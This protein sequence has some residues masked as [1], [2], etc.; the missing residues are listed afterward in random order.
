M[1]EELSDF[2][3]AALLQSDEA[4]AVFLSDAFETGNASH[5]ATALEVAIRTKG[6]GRIASKAGLPGGGYDLDNPTLA[7]I[8]AVMKA[9]GVGFSPML[10]R[11]AS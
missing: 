3:P 5:I 4:I 6:E 10:V 11:P 7:T 2:D 1:A 8:L 9:L